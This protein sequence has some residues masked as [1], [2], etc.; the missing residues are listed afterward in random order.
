MPGLW[1]AFSRFAGAP[2][3]RCDKVR[4]P[5][6]LSRLRRLSYQLCQEAILSKGTVK[7]NGGP[8]K[9]NAALVGQRQQ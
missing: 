4:P 7:A 8:T 1:L 5:I 3:G 6:L 9:D 2:K